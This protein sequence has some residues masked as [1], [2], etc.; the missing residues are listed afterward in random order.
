MLNNNSTKAGVNYRPNLMV[1]KTMAHEVIHAEMYRKMMAIAKDPNFD[2]FTRQELTDLLSNDDYPG[3]YYYY[4]KYVKGWQHQQM[5]N[6]Y[7]E[8]IADI[9]Q[10]FDRFQHSRQFYMDLAWEGLM[11][12]DIDAWA[13][14]SN[15]EKARI[16]NVV[17]NYIE[18]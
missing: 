8:T 9:I 10:R 6:H 14:K 1:A 5:A 15:A 16:E 11:Y 12:D 2:N 7:R 3:I 17:L 18:K 4:R 13:N